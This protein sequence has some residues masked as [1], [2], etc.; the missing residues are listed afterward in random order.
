M[1]ITVKQ[2]INLQKELFLFLGEKMSVGYKFK[3][4]VFFNEIT[5]LVELAKAKYDEV[6][7]KYSGKARGIP[8]ELPNGD[9]NPDIR[10][11]NEE[12]EP[13]MTEEVE[14]N[15]PEI[16]ISENKQ[17]FDS[18]SENFYP[19]MIKLGILCIN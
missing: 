16:I 4:T 19:T 18:V 1:K 17:L 11:F 10:L 2:A 3:L 15:L 9:I 12:V 5:P 7:L 13:I 14:L 6:L 8:E